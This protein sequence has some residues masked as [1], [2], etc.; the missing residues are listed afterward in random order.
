M[1]RIIKIVSG[2]QSGV[3]RAALDFA[4]ENKISCGGWCPKGRLAEDGKIHK[5]FPL[6]ETDSADYRV[7]TQNNVRDSDGTLILYVDVLGDGTAL[8]QRIAKKLMK[9]YLLLLLNGENYSEK[10]VQLKSWMEANKIETLNVAGPR[11]S[12]N[13]GIYTKTLK[14][15][16]MAFTSALIS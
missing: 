2:G 7:R 8:T 14:F 10:I 12:S 5:R 13:P 6:Y 3:D 4:L 1:I 16:E 11:E 9:P 15:F